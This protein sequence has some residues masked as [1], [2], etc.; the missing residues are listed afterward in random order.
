MNTVRVSCPECSCEVRCSIDLV[1]VFAVEPEDTHMLVLFRCPVCKGARLKST[2]T[3]HLPVLMKAGALVENTPDEMCDSKRFDDRPALRHN[4]VLDFVLEL[5]RWD[6]RV[7]S[8][9]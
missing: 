9:E 2:T 8:R 7:A 3:E 5:R 6:G 4:D 1:R